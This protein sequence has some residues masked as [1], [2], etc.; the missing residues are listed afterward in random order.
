MQH[1]LKLCHLPRLMS[2]NL[3]HERVAIPQALWVVK[4]RRGR[5]GRGVVEIARSE[6]EV[7]GRG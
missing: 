1:L 3:R 2:V 4:Q 6:G 7:V 5:H